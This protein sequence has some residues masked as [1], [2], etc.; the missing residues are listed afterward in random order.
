[1]AAPKQPQDHKTKAAEADALKTPFEFTGA[2]GET[3][4]LP[5]FS[6]SDAGLTAGFVR[7]NR[8]NETELLYTIV[9]ALASEETLDALDELSPERFGE[10]IQAWQ[11][12][13]GAELPKS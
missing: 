3:Y 6:V 9:E 2:D 11:A 10:V 12:A 7:K 1:M 5:H 8:K 4:E 13:S